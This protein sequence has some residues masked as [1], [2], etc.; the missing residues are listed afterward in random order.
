MPVVKLKPGTRASLSS[1]C[2]KIDIGIGL[3]SGKFHILAFVDIAAVIKTVKANEAVWYGEPRTEEGYIYDDTKNCNG[4]SWGDDDLRIVI[5][6]DKITND[7]E[8]IFVV[9]NFFSGAKENFGMVE[10]GYIKVY[11]HETKECLYEYD[12]IDWSMHKGKKGLIW[13]EIYPHKGEWKLKCVD[14]SIDS[15]NLGEIVKKVSM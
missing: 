15:D 1:I 5:N 14:T 3:K 7:V 9:T 4:T 10:S 2:N 12:N 8:R 13:C 11:N 6:F